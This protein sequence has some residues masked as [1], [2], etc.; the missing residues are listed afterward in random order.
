MEKRKGPMAR[1]PHADGFKLHLAA[2]ER[3]RGGPFIEGLTPPQ[4]NHPGPPPSHVVEIICWS[5][6]QI[7]QNDLNSYISWELWAIL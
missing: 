2:G 1:A 7:L 3:E 5:L 6:R 4:K